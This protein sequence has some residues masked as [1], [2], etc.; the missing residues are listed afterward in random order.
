MLLGGWPCAT[1]IV[2]WSRVPSSSEVCL[3][4]IYSAFP[5][6]AVADDADCYLVRPFLG[7]VWPQL[8]E[9]PVFTAGHLCP[10]TCDGLLHDPSACPMNEPLLAIQSLQ[11]LNQFILFILLI[12]CW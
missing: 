9:G 1:P 5:T 2:L 4:L 6:G 12:A 10:A 8:S 11:R 3:R 7:P